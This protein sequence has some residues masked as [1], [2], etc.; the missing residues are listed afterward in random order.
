MNII[1]MNKLYVFS[2]LLLSLLLGACSEE[3]LGLYDEATAALNIA[4]GTAFGPLS[5][6]PEEYSFNAYFLGGQLTHYT[7]PIP[8]RL[9][10][11]VDNEHDRHY[12]VTVV[13]S[14]CQGNI[15][16]Q[17]LTL[18]REQ[19][20]RRGLAQDSI[21]LTIHLNEMDEEQNYRVRIAL[22]PSADFAQGV[23]QCQYVD[24]SFTKNLS[25]APPF[26]ENNSKLRRITYL[27]RK[28]AVFL[29]ISGLT[30]PNWIDDGSTVILEYWITL[31]NQW[32]LE[33][34]EYDANGNRIYF[35][36]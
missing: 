5:E 15:T 11:I 21:L 29:Q 23:A 28:C 32:F 7:L 17:L 36:D 20:F 14:A 30:D 26:W 33:H 35:S 2:T 31:C 10:G 25:I 27:P 9:Q 6:Y 24:V 22:L 4:K 1:S 3:K 16:P 12:Q 18:Q 8:V 19:V 34:E 13:D